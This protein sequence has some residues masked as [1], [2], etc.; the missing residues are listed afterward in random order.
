MGGEHVPWRG[1]KGITL[2]GPVL[3]FLGR[4]TVG[5]KE[6]AL[7]DGRKSNSLKFLQKG[8]ADVDPEEKSIARSGSWG[9]V[10]E[11]D[12]W[13]QKDSLRSVQTGGRFLGRGGDQRRN[14][15]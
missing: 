7:I 2:N 14:R 6:G 13:T 3:G 12:R 10:P 5:Q 8:D 9:G 1:K 11:R 15:G 4:G